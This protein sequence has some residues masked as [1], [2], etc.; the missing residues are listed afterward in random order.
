MEWIP[1]V[2]KKGGILL[3]FLLK[4]TERGKADE[5]GERDETKILSTR[6]CSFFFFFKLTFK[7]FFGIF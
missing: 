7:I 6:N 1:V 3:H 4:P 5:V 2:V